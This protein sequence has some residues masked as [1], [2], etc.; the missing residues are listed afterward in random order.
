MSRLRHTGCPG[1]PVFKTQ[2]DR[3]TILPVTYRHLADTLDVPLGTR[4]P[5]T[6][7]VTAVLTDRHA[8]GLLLPVGGPDARQADSVFL[9]PPLTLAQAD[10]VRA[11]GG[12]VFGGTDATMVRVSAGW[13]LQQC[14]HHPCHRLRHHAARPG[15]PRGAADGHPAPPR[16]HHG[17]P[18]L[19]RTTGSTPI[20]GLNLS[21]GRG[22]AEEIGA[23]CLPGPSSRG[24]GQ[25]MSKHTPM[26][27]EASARIQSAAA[28]NPDSDSAQDDFDRRAQSAADKNEDREEDQQDD[29]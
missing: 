21:S 22:L 1:R 27:K 4:P 12:P 11:A 14:G 3:S 28:R 26:D 6:E 24:Y 13:L 16:T 7:A 20:G 5:L 8:R 25:R 9:N 19:K 23:R 15:R 29:D 2:P 18:P 17:R 10:A